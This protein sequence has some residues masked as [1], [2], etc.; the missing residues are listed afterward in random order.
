MIQ[1][2]PIN[3]TYACASTFTITKTKTHKDNDQDNVHYPLKDISLKNI[4]NKQQCFIQ[5]NHV[6]STHS[7]KQ[8]L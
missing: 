7:P 3:V 6:L 1:N 5:N 4:Q 8:T 2:L